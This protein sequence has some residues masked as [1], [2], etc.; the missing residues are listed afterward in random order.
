ML[1]RDST[2]ARINLVDLGSWILPVSST[3]VIVR[4]VISSSRRGRTSFT[5]LDLTWYARRCESLG[6]RKAVG[7]AFRGSWSCDCLMGAMKTR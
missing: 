2:S 5:A 1:F 4:A 7:C 3:N 6:G